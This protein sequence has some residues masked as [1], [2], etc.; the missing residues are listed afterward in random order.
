M[1]EADT[2]ITDVKPQKFCFACGK[3]VQGHRRVKDS[4]GYQCMDCYKAEKKAARPIGK[5]AHLREDEDDKRRKRYQKRIGTA[6]YD[7][8]ERRNLLIMAGIVAVLAVIILL[9]S[10]GVIT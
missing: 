6:R 9:A 8:H 7:E 4:R 5:A 3:S 1:T 10:L 2:E